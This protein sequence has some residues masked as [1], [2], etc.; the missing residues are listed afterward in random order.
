VKY[1]AV[2]GVQTQITHSFSCVSSQFLVMFQIIF[3]FS[4]YRLI[5]RDDVVIIDAGNYIKGKY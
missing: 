1:W 2:A 4:F 5:G 3:F